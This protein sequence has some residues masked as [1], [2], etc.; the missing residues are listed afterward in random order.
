MKNKEYLFTVEAEVDFMKLLVLNTRKIGIS[1]V[2][3]SMR[4]KEFTFTFLEMFNYL[5]E[6][7]RE[8]E[9]RRIQSIAATPMCPTPHTRTHR[10]GA[11]TLWTLREE[12]HTHH[13]TLVRGEPSPNPK[14]A[15]P[16]RGIVGHGA[17]G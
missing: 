13:S 3:C 12:Q 6:K 14:G 7:L 16:Q 15:H 1:R 10:A 9:S 11:H 17:Q 8:E 2:G 4:K 5:E